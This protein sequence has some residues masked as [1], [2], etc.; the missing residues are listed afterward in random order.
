MLTLPD[1][2]LTYATDVHSIQRMTPERNPARMYR[3]NAR[4]DAEAHAQLQALEAHTRLSTTD[5]L[6]EALRRMHA[7]TVASTSR[8][9]SALDHLVGKYQGAPADL[10]ERTK[11][12]L[13]ASLSRKHTR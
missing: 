13:T 5:V 6:R 3:V 8:A 4:L 11:T 9:R 2:P 1:A 12:A 10:S 7:D